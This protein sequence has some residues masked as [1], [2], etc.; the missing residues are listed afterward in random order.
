MYKAVHVDGA[1]SGEIVSTYISIA[2]Q[3]RGGH[4]I[5]TGAGKLEWSKTDT[6]I[7]L[8]AARTGTVIKSINGIRFT[9]IA[10]IPALGDAVWVEH[11]EVVVEAMVLLE[12]ED[13]MV[14]GI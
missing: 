13:D 14:D 6:F 12:H 9:V 1:R 3:P 2:F 11:A 10:D 7:T 5:Y 4:V 8:I